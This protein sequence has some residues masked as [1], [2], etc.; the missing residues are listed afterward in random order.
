[1]VMYH[2]PIINLINTCQFLSCINHPFSFI[3]HTNSFQL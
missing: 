2:N 1:M 3:L